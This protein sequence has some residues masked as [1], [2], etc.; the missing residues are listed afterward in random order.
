M[1][2]SVLDP[3]IAAYTARMD[4]LHRIERVTRGWSEAQLAELADAI[5]KTIITPLTIAADLEGSK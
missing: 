5:E 1:K 3:L 2:P 4:H